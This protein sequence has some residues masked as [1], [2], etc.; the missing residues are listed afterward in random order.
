MMIHQYLLLTQ[1]LSCCSMGI[2]SS[3][4][5]SFMFSSVMRSRVK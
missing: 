4:M 1:P 2:F 5:L 3:L